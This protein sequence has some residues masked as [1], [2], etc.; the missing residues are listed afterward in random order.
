MHPCMV[1][2]QRDRV[3]RLM[4]ENLGNLTSRRW[5]VFQCYLHCSPMP[6]ADYCRGSL[7]SQGTLVVHITVSQQYSVS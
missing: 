1:R 3:D 2:L 6:I 7:G 4:S 5:T